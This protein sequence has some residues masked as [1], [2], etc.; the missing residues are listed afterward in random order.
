MK[1][2]Y[3]REKMLEFCRQH[4]GLESLSVSCSVEQ[5][6]GISFDALLEADMRHRY[7]D[8]LDNGP[9]NL[10]Y[11]KEIGPVAHFDPRPDNLPQ[12]WGLVEPP[13]GCRRILSIRLDGWSA[14]AL[15]L[16]AT[17]LPA[18]L[19]RQANPYTVATAE[20]PVA[21]LLPAG[22]VAVTPLSIEAMI[23]PRVSSMTAA[24]DEGPQTYSFDEAALGRIIDLVKI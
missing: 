17:E 22:S 18:V 9:E 19:A 21:V 16:P 23:N 11:P 13:N 5:T 20:M 15:P 8:L 4:G 7:L 10:L 12:G 24:Y 1:V 3:S 2:S 14:P 6:D